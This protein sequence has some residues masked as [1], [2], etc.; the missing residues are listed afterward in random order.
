MRTDAV[1]VVKPSRQIAEQVGGGPQVGEVDVIAFEV[2]DEG[3]DACRRGK[4]AIA[5]RLDRTPSDAELRARGQR[6]VSNT[7]VAR[8]KRQ[9]TSMPLA[10]RARSGDPAKA[11][12]RW[13]PA[14]G[15]A[16]PQG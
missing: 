1:V 4:L 9:V 5:R 7:R 10:W 6:K 13:R 8:W 2:L 12:G 14:S 15:A 11:D 16:A 3:N